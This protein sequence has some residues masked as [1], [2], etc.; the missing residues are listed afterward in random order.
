M[1][2]SSFFSNASCVTFTSRSPFLNMRSLVLA[3]LVFS[4]LFGATPK[5]KTKKPHRTPRTKYWLPSR[6]PTSTKDGTSPPSASEMSALQRVLQSENQRIVQDPYLLQ[7]V[8]H[9]SDRVSKAAILALGRVGDPYSIEALSTVLNGKNPAKKQLA[10]LSLGLIGDDVSVKLLTQHLAME[11]NAD[12]RGTYYRSLGYSRNQAGLNLLVKALST[13][14]QSK[15]Q[16]NVVE[17]LGLLLSG[18]SAAWDIPEE[19]L[20][21]LLKHTKANKETAVNAAFALSQYKGSL[22]KLPTD[23]LLASVNSAPLAYARSFLIK[24]IGRLDHPQGTTVL[25]NHLSE[26]QPLSVTIEAMKSLKGKKLS[27]SSSQ[28]FKKLLESKDSQL[29][30]ATLETLRASKEP[31]L[32]ATADVESL[33]RNSKSPWVRGSALKTLCQISPEA[34]KKIIAETLKSQNP[35]EQS[36]AIA[37]L[38]ILKT[39]ESFLQLSAFLKQQKPQLISEAIEQLALL[40]SEQIPENIKATLKELIKTKDIGLIALISDLAKNKGWKDF[41]IPLVEVYSSFQTDETTETKSTLLSSLSVIGTDAEIPLLT[42]ALNDNS[43]WV[44]AAAAQAIK[45]ITGAAP[46][47]NI[48]INNRITELTPQFDQLRSALRKNVILKTNRGEIEIQFF[49]EAPLT[50]FKFVELVR[51]NFYTRKNFHRVVPSFVAQGGDPRGDGFGGPGFLIRDEVSSLNHDRG[52]LGIAT[53][54][55]DTG[56]SQFFF[57]LGPNYHLNGRY[58]VFAKIISGLEVMDKIEVGDYI[59]SASIK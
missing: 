28:I 4:S 31:S 45:A 25:L 37:S 32:W 55:K 57:N 36:A 16:A 27:E 2:A 13:E 53:S 41:R 23:Q 22:K 48:P 14:T 8:L 7:A 17:G 39:P 38:A 49:E 20:Q 44:V 46:E 52:T 40:D 58:T 1:V 59:I 5:S 50:A 51:A 10:A 42:S 15:V 21:Q 19:V 56:G 43:K 29:L 11:K 33:I 47:K 35:I 18:N 6:I 34:G 30:V 3:L 9:T 26:N 12:L 54:G 24:V